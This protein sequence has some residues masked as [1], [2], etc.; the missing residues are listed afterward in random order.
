MKL[1][2]P[3]PGARLSAVALVVTAIVFGALISW[4]Y[5]ANR[6]DRTL[7][8]VLH[9][10]VAGTG[11]QIGKPG[12]A[13]YAY[14]REHKDELDRARAQYADFLAQLPCKGSKSKRKETIQ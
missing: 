3:P 10:L 4:A 12:T 13:G 2:I 8:D 1:L 6:R 14:F 5:T 9:D 11:A 7:C